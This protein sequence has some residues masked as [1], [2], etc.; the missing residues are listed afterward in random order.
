MKSGIK[1]LILIFMGG[2]L[3]SGCYYD[4]EEELYPAPD[5]C[6][7]TAVSFAADVQPIINNNCISCHSGNTP[8]GNLRLENYS[9]ISAN[10]N[11]IYNR[12]SLPVT[13]VN[14]MPPGIQ[15]DDCIILKIKTW[16]DNG[17]PDNKK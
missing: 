5:D 12:I 8:S 1:F 16:L 17:T 7:T 14:H 2:L 13:D 3:M 15:L 11:N 4:N 10:A 6:D 9:Q